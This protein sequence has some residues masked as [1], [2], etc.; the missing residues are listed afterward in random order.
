MPDDSNAAPPDLPRPFSGRLA[1]LRGEKRA[2]AR[3]LWRFHHALTD[4]QAPRLDGD[5]LTAYFEAEKQKA[6]ARDPLKVVPD[7]VG[8]AAYDACEAHD[9]PE[10]LPA[11][12]IGAARRFKRE[13]VRFPERA[14]LDAWLKAWARPHGLLLAK[15]AGAGHSWQ[16]RPVFELA[17]GFFLTNRLLRL[18][19]DL[20]DDRLFFPETDLEQYGVTARDL[21]DGPVEGQPPCEA[22]QR[23][24]W[25]QNV[26]ARDA[27][28]QGQ[29]ALAGELPRRYA[30]TL[31]ACWLGA[32]DLLD[33]L[34]ARDHDLWHA[35]PPRLPWWRRSQVYLQAF[36]GRS[37]R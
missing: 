18:P 31:R 8:R 4:P 22:V 35:S 27:L 1:W 10:T 36:L 25:K 33:Q 12:Q 15:L 14:D 23:L 19:H 34:E 11:R 16:E 9:L 29:N 20:R 13:R 30:W 5:D 24:L 2:A 7:D 6:T 3:A 37:G 32:L 21:R 28:A 17:R 26:R